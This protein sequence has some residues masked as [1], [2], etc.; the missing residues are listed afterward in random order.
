MLII[1]FSIKWIYLESSCF[2]FLKN[3]LEN[4]WFCLNDMFENMMKM[5]KSRVGLVCFSPCNFIFKSLRCHTMSV[6][7]PTVSLYHRFSSHF[8]DFPRK[9]KI[10]FLQD[11]NLCKILPSYSI[12]FRDYALANLHCFRQEK[13]SSLFLALNPLFSS[14]KTF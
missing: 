12:I 10:S 3:D 9:N 4:D 14:G 11:Q 13:V 6:K 5:I 1:N 2:Y 8:V 7:N